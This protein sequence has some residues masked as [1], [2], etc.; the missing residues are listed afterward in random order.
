MNTAYKW[1]E[2]PE[3]AN[4]FSAEIGVLK[5]GLG[6]DFELIKLFEPQEADGRIVCVGNL[7]YDPGKTQ[8]IQITFP[9][10]YPY[11]PPRI[12]SVALN[13]APDGT[14][15]IPVAPFHFGK[16]NQY[17]DGALCLFRN[18]FWDSGQHN[19]GWALRR[20]QKWLRSVNSKEGFKPDEVVEEHAAPINHIGQ[21]LLPKEID[22]P[23]EAQ[24]GE[25]ILTQF[26]PNH[27]ILV[28][29]ELTNSPFQ[30]Q[31][32]K[33][34]FKWY[35]LERGETFRSLLPILNG[36]TVYKLFESRFGVNILEGSPTKNVALYIPDDD[37]SW[38]FFKLIVANGF[39]GIQIAVNYF[40][41]RTL[42]KELFLRTSTMFDDQVLATKNVTIIGVG[43]I[44]S[45]VS[46][47]LA[48]NG[49]GHFNLFDNDTF[50]VGN[51]V[52]H[53]ADLYYIGESKVDVTKAL[54]QRSNPNITVNTYRIDILN[55]TGL[56]EACLSKSHLCIILTGDESVDYLINDKYHARFSIPFVFARVSA[57]AI[58]GSIQI[59]DGESACLRCLSM[60]NLDLLPK[61][62]TKSLYSEL[63]SEYGSCS[64]PAL[65]GSEI[66]TK[67]IALQVSRIALQLLIP[68]GSI[69]YPK[70][71]GKQYYWHGPFGSDT[72]LPFT[73]ETKNYDKDPDCRVC[74]R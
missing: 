45:E 24:S 55:D 66:D 40:L 9:T 4:L 41:A 71:S 39:G 12:I 74:G 3:L 49:I 36:E 69:T 68:E 28:D 7:A 23:G 70:V 11:A 65:P 18:D 32:N 21:V 8:S 42:S 27:F 54:I 44:G 52:R 1:H 33:E 26:K 25:F 56:L 16:G 61:G 22:L 35:R 34:A 60:S 47:S 29:N 43:A 13:F 67:E 63:R 31:I 5:R 17:A 53:A 72:E 37:N 48:R 73:W 6:G 46:R 2:D 19:I 64:S 58:S 51:S 15:L 30:L 59:V 38:H 62:N 50:E 20:A 10:K 14:L 57:G